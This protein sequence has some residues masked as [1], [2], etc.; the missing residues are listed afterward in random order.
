MRMFEI[1][2]VGGFEAAHRLN[3][4]FGPA[5]RQHGHTYRVEAV[6]RGP[7]L[8]PNGTLCDITVLQQALG[9]A[10]GALHY[11]DLAEVPELAGQNTTA[12]VVAQHVFRQVV[13]RL[14]GLGLETLAVRVWE[15]PSAYAG[16]EGPVESV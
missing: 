3:G 10:T 7:R 12:E 15:S 4:D 1:G 5:A 13:P 6:V 9:E 8:Q 2:V 11:R 16:L 14:R